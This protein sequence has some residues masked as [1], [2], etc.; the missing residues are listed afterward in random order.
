MLQASISLLVVRR[1]NKQGQT[2]SPRSAEL[3]P[4]KLAFVPMEDVEGQDRTR[5][6]AKNAPAANELE[7]I[8]HQSRDTHSVT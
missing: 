7:I 8:D 5:L 1:T 2:T 3:P 6:V 4:T